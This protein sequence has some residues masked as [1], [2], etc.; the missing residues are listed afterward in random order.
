MSLY[1]SLHFTLLRSVFSLVVGATTDNFDIVFPYFEL[2]AKLTL[3]MSLMLSSNLF[4]CL[5]FLVPSTVPCRI[6]SPYQGNIRC[7]YTV[8]IS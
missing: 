7:D 6:S 5:P 3:V 2:L 4:F 1:M 8:F